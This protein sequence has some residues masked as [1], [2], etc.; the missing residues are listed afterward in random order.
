MGGGKLQCIIWW[1]C[2][3]YTR[4]AFPP[5]PLLPL[6]LPWSSHSPCPEMP[7]PKWSPLHPPLPLPL[8]PPLRALPGPHWP[9]GPRTAQRPAS[10]CSTAQHNTA[11]HHTISASL[12]HLCTQHHGISGAPLCTVGDTAVPLCT[13]VIQRYTP[14]P[15]APGATPKAS[16][17]P[18]NTRGIKLGP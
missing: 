5:R 4:P 11:Q 17:G 16:S 1:A 13:S 18:H 3:H 6:T 12:L 7:P 8:L 15:A 10:D 14:P 9:A 2:M